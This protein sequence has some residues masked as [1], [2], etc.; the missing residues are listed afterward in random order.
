MPHQPPLL[1][2]LTDTWVS[3]PATGATLGTTQVFA[4]PATS[5]AKIRAVGAAGGGAAQACNSTAIAAVDSQVV[6]HR[7][8]F[9]TSQSPASVCGSDV[10]QLS[11]AQGHFL[12][13]PSTMTVKPKSTSRVG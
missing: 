4:P 10:G 12:L 5:A 3:L 9:I 6:V 13:R 2:T 7:L 11:P 1:P 8:P